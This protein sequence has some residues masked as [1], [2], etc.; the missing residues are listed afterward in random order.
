MYSLSKVDDAVDFVVDHEFVHRVKV[1]D[2]GLDEGVVLL[3]FNVLEVGKVAGVCE[4]VDVDDVV[5]GVFVHEEAYYVAAD[6][7][8]SA[9]Y[10]YAALH[11]L[12]LLFV[13][14]FYSFYAVFH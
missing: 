8:G 14:G 3:V 6:E 11:I 10:Y 7:S 9:C 2:V 12:F 5:V 4:L 1:A 13:V